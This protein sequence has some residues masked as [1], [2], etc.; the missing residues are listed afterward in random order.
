MEEILN[1]LECCE[2]MS[3][4]YCQKCFYLDEYVSSD[5][6]PTCTARL[7]HDVLVLLK[8]QKPIAPHMI[9]WGIYECPKCKT[10]VDTT[11]NY[12]KCCGQ[13]VKW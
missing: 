2:H 9:D 10:R 11:Y 12:C 5:T 8:A 7:A 13:A 4:A 6:L 3:G 1:A